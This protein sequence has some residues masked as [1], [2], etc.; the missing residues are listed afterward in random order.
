MVLE[1]LLSVA[2][3]VVAGGFFAFLLRIA[4]DGYSGTCAGMAL[5]WPFFLPISIGV[6]IVTNA[7]EARERRRF[8][9]PPP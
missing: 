8:E 9:E 3:L 7:I 2:Y 1:L 4:P 6:A 5:L